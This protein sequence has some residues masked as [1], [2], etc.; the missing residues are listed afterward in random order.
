MKKK[1][2]IHLNLQKSIKFKSRA[3]SKITNQIQNQ[4]VKPS[5]ILVSITFVMADLTLRIL[6]TMNKQF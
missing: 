4:Y 3:Y 1:L 6:I 5:K 2:N